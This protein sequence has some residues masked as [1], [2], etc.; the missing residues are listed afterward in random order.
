MPKKAL[1]DP[2]IIEFDAEVVRS[3]KT[4]CRMVIFPHNV[5][6]LYGVR[7]V[8]PVHVLF[9]G[10]KSQGP[11]Y[12][13]GK[14][15]PHFLLLRKPIREALGVEGGDKVH[16]VVSLK[17]IKQEKAK[18]DDLSPQVVP[19]VEPAAPMKRSLPEDSTA[20]TSDVNAEDNAPP[21]RAKRSR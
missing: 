2:G 17:P 10:M 7:G 14:G 6:E 16:V 15:R 13:P 5:E 1:S 18:Q 19:D 3:D 4:S 21:K 12:N 9:N 20:A 8:V 11:L